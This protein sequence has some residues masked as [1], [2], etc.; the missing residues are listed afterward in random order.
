[1]GRTFR[2]SVLLAAVL[3]VGPAMQAQQ[4]FHPL[5]S[6][7]AVTYTAE[8]AKIASI[9]CGCFWLQGGSASGAIALFRG[10]GVAANLTGE[11]ASNIAPG[12]DLSK[13]VF[14][15]GPRYTLDGRRGK[16]GWLGANHEISIFGEALFGIVHGFDSVFPTA[17]GADTSANSF[18]LQVGGGLNIGLTKHFGLRALEIDYVHTRLPN[19]FGNTQNDL[20]FAFGVTYHLGKR[21]GNSP[22]DH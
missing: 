17:S 22:P 16:N 21:R 13:L 3:S 9:D 8:R 10:L 20:R 6:D 18:S 2:R 5:S 11:H 1:M 12:V 4:G 7:L 19:S 15:A 14:M